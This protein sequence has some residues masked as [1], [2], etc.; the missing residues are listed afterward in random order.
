M[1]RLVHVSYSPSV[2]A[3]NH[4]APAHFLVHDPSYCTKM[5][6]LTYLSFAALAAH[7]SAQDIDTSDY[8][9]ACQQYCAPVAARAT[10]CDINGDEDDDDNDDCVC[11]GQGMSTAIPRCDACV[12]PFRVPGDD[13]YS[14][15]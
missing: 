4:Y 3:L 8:P 11:N 2:T 6:T 7:A 13:D 9:A 15:E 5:K 14:G 1:I 12:A 10:A